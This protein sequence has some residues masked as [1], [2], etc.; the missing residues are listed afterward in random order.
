[1]LI[2]HI[3]FLLSVINNGFIIQ[4]AYASFGATNSGSVTM[5]FPIAHTWPY[6]IIAQPCGH[7]TFFGFNLKDWGHTYATF[8]WWGNTNNDSRWGIQL[9]TV[10]IYF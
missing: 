7:G 10:G 4:W 8:I 2:V 3:I 1:M 6:R 9:L 5:T